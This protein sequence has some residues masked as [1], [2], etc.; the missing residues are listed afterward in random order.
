MAIAR[1]PRA[2]RRRRSLAVKARAQGQREGGFEGLSERGVYPIAAEVGGAGP[3][4]AGAPAR[5]RW[6]RNGLHGAGILDSGDDAQPAA[7]AGTGQDIE[8]EHAGHQRRPGPGVRDGG[9]GA[10]LERKG[11]A[12]RGWAASSCLFAGTHAR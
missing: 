8:V 12:V 7:T 3:G 4:D 1:W 6:A 10:G 5:A 2:I 11:V 9:A